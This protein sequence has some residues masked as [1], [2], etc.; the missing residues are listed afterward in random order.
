MAERGGFDPPRTVRPYT[1]SSRALPNGC[2]DPR[3]VN[4][5]RM[6]IKEEDCNGL[7]RW[8]YSSAYSTVIL[9]ITF[10]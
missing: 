6:A 9:Q 7:S 10:G 8:N 3:G 1:I 5:P 2:Y 4:F